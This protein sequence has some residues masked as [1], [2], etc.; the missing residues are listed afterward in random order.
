MNL[1]NPHT[2][3]G[4]GL[5][6]ISLPT[7]QEGILTYFVLGLMNSFFFLFFKQK[8]KSPPHARST[9]HLGLTMISA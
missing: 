2:K 3:P 8:F 6:E 7:L 4:G 1:A 9:D 5:K